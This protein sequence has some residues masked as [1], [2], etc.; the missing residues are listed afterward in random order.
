MTYQD[1]IQEWGERPPLFIVLSTGFGSF[2]VSYEFREHPR[3]KRPKKILL[4]FLFSFKIKL[5]R[6]LNFP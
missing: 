6:P 4:F 5:S 1:T 2:L 3:Y